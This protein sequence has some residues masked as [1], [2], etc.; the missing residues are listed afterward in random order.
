MQGDE[1]YEKGV[2][3]QMSK[4]DC[5]SNREVQTYCSMYSGA[6][7]SLNP[8]FIYRLYAMRWWGVLL[9]FIGYML[10]N[11]C[12]CICI[13]TNSSTTNRQKNVR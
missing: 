2:W 4:F 8:S 7:Y 3:P 13:C 6:Q 5:H 11:I 1:Q 12:I 9:L 10:I